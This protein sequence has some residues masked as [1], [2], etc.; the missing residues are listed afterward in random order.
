MPC[1][2]TEPSIE[3]GLFI[4]KTYVDVL[5]TKVISFESIGGKLT[6][7]I[8]QLV[9]AGLTLPKTNVHVHAEHAALA[10]LGFTVTLGV[11]GA[12]L[13]LSITLTTGE[14]IVCWSC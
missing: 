14:L 8:S 2:L 13:L 12:I 6:R 11:L 7:V 10:P 1:S 3:E 4:N 9:T 5:D